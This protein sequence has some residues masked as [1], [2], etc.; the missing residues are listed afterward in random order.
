MGEAIAARVRRYIHDGSDEDLRRLLRLSELL[1]D[2]LRAALGRVGVAEGWRTIECGCGPLGG[3]AVLAEMVGASGQVVGVDFNESAVERA[4]SVVATLALSNV[5]VVVGDVL[6]IDLATLGGPFDLAYTRC[7][8]MHQRDPARVLTRIADVVRPGGW[9]VAHEPLRSPPPRS[10]P[11]LDLLDAYWELMHEL[12]E[13]VG[14]PQSLVEDLPR[15][16][17]A[18]GLEIADGHG[19]FNLREPKTGFELHADTLAAM[20]GRAI[21][22]G[23]ATAAEVDG[24]IS[25]L[26]VA[27]DGGYE[28][29]TSPFFLDLTLRRPAATHGTST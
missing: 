12:M 1:A 2:N 26:R 13:W 22:S 3:L 5:E 6:D 24:L 9:V 8:L 21:E 29:V 20:K 27:K 17:H 15:A 11:H 7:F 28:W 4:R 25:A 19:F 16:A 14:V 23:I 18:A 10:C